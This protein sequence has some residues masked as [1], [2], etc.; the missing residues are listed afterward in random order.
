MS[1]INIKNQLPEPINVSYTAKD[2]N[3]IKQSV[4][5][6]KAKASIKELKDDSS[7]KVSTSNNNK[8]ITYETGNKTL[9]VRQEGSPNDF[10]LIWQ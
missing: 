4:G 2:G 8:M 1:K 7:I 3:S 9:E 10:G 5:A 6:R